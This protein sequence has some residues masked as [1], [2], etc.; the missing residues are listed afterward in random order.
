MRNFY[1]Q[2]FYRHLRWLILRLKPM[3]HSLVT[4]NFSNAKNVVIVQKTGKKSFRII[5]GILKDFANA[6]VAL[7]FFALL[8]CG[9]KVAALPSSFLVP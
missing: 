9:M 2:P 6:F 3:F 8:Q 5:Y 7:T 4:I 1:K